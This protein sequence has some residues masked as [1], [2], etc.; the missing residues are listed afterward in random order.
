VRSRAI[1][2]VVL[3]VALGGCAGSASLAWPPP[4]Q[5][6]LKD[7]WVVRHAWHTRLAL[8][9]AD[10]DPS[11]WPEIGELGDVAYVEVGWGDRDY[12]PSPAPSIWDALDTIIR[13]TPAALHVGGYDRPPPDAVPGTPIVRIQVSAD[14]FARLTRFI[15]AYYVLEDGVPVRIG[16]G[17]SPRS[18]FYR[19]HG[20]YHALANS[21]NWTLSALQAAG[22]PVAPWRALT[23]GHVITQ[24]EAIG[25]RVDTGRPSRP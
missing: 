2:T 20:R 18:W 19:A 12:Y 16:P 14:G 24:A 6:A 5:A 10:V 15:H 8:A 23:A 3:G 17:P 22:A 21:N 1:A 9:R 7:V 25:E 4:T 13:P 11:I